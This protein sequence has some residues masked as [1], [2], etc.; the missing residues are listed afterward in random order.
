M[1]HIPSTVTTTE[2]MQIFFDGLRQGIQPRMHYQGC[3]AYVREQAACD[4]PLGVAGRALGVEV[5]DAPT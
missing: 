3:G 5:P 4:C 2:S 1:I